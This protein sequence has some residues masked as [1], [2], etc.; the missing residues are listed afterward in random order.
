MSGEEERK[1]EAE[2][3]R[4]RKAEGET[5]ESVIGGEDGDGQERTGECH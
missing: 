4:E 1:L 3:G 5:G 2:V